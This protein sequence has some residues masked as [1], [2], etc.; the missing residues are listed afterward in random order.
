LL[1]LTS[2]ITTGLALEGAAWST[3]RLVLND[4]EAVR[5]NPSQIR[6]VQSDDSSV[7]KSAV[8]LPVYLNN[9][10]SDVLFTV[11]LPFDSS[12]GALVAMR[13]VCLTAGG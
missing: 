9:D 7:S 10:R 2:F 1:D 3:D 11:D 12:A 6:W 8:N 13:A 4:G 5:L